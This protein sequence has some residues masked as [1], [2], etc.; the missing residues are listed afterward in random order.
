MYY[1]FIIT[2]DV[3]ME[4]GIIG[5]AEMPEL[6]SRFEAAARGHAAKFTA[7]RGGLMFAE[8]EDSY[9]LLTVCQSETAI[10]S[11]CVFDC[12]ENAMDVAFGSNNNQ[13]NPTPYDTRRKVGPASVAP[14]LIIW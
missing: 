6:L 7:L 12:I 8:R 4:R 13:G 1:H 9:V 5:F 3:A 14:F 2:T 10:P 11:R